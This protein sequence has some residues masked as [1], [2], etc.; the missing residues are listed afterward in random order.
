MPLGRVN[1]IVINPNRRAEALPAVGAAGEH[2]VGSSARAH[3][4]HHVNVVV[5]R[6]TGAVNRQEHLPGQP[7]RINSAAINRAPAHVDC[8][9]LVKCGRDIWVLRVGRTNTPKLAA[10]C[11]SAAAYKQVPVASHIE[12][13]PLRIIWDVKR[14]LPRG[15]GIGRPAE[16]AGVAIEVVGPKLILKAVTHAGGGPI[17]RKP[18]FIAA[19][20]SSL[21]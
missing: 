18:L 10:A 19:V 20:R 2:D 12:G 8:S 9:D 6:A 5:S 21:W 15:S 17:K 14:T 1:R 7:A 4:G 3:A 16:S 11:A 13:S